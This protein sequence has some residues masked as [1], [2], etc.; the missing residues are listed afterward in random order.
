MRRRRIGL[1]VAAVAAAA[2]AAP[3]Q[4][5]TGHSSI[6]DV[7]GDANGT[8]S[9]PYGGPGP[10]D[11]QAGPVSIPALDITAAAIVHGTTARPNDTVT[12][13]LLQ[14]DPT[15]AQ[16]ITV[17]IATPGCSHVTIE[18]ESSYDGALLAGCHGTQ[19][20]YLSSPR[21]NGDTLTFTLPSPLPRWL[22]AGTKVTRLDV[23]STTDVELWPVGALY[24]PGDYA[25]G[26]ID[27]TF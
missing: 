13:R 2:V 16:G 3:V 6:T 12:V 11:E 9:R 26:A 27:T 7:S 20:A 4:A 25:S 14:A 8:D 10:T 22:P 21:F 15:M 17:T 18:W 23:Q 24:P 19:R 5:A 1:A